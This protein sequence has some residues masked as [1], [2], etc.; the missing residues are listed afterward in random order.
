MPAVFT[1]ISQFY[2]CLAVI[3]K[4]FCYSKTDVS[5]F[6]N[7]GRILGKRCLQAGIHFIQRP[8]I[9]GDEERKSE[10]ISAFYRALHESGLILEEPA[11]VKQVY[12]WEFPEP[13]KAGMP[14]EEELALDKTI[15]AQTTTEAKP[16]KKAKK[17][18]AIQSEAV[19]SLKD[20]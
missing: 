16:Q 5:A 9:E 2:H 17:A 19:E 1:G 13:E 15:E 11:V 7:I 6:E 10:K 14:L 12:P 20:N 18:K 8:T 4:F 3:A